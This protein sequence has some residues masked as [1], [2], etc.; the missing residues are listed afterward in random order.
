MTR[1]IPL[2]Y[3]A[4]AKANGVDPHTNVT[5]A[6]DVG[7]ETFFDTLTSIYMDSDP[8]HLVD[9]WW[10]DYSVRAHYSIPPAFSFT[11]VWRP[12]PSPPYNEGPATS[13]S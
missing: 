3:P 7:N 4:F 10:T 12:P 8:L 6:C 5:V 2:R 9:V 1:R 11:R 13:S